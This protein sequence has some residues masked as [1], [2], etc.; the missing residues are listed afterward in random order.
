[1]LDPHNLANLL[2]RES[3]SEIKFLDHIFVVIPI[4]RHNEILLDTQVVV[5]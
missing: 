2:E 5:E 3:L 4:L 1:M